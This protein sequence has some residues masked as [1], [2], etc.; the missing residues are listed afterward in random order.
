MR[1]KQ[2]A[3]RPKS[4]PSS[5]AGAS[6]CRHC[7]LASESSST[8]DDSGSNSRCSAAT[9]KHAPGK[10]CQLPSCCP[11]GCAGSWVPTGC[12]CRVWTNCPGRRSEPWSPGGCSH[13]TEY[14]N[15]AS[16]LSAEAGLSHQHEGGPIGHGIGSGQARGEKASANHVLA[17][18]G[19]QQVLRVAGERL[20]GG[21]GILS[22]GS[23]GN[24]VKEMVV[25]RLVHGS[26]LM[27]HRSPLSGNPS[28]IASPRS[29][30]RE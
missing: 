5:P 7:L 21:L 27:Q 30:S 4:R 13:S 16:G 15:T 8:R 2:P 20:C 1:T 24:P 14:C 12:Y 3:F 29:L 17:Y 28:R 26:P 9:S 10:R 25:L 11:S 22:Q 6:S 23:C 18:A 19:P